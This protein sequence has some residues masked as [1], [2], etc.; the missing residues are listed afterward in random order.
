[1]E[2]A[3]VVVTGLI[4]V[5]TLVVAAVVVA[6]L[7]E[8]GKTVEVSAVVVVW[9]RLVAMGVEVVELVVT[10]GAA[11]VGVGLEVSPHASNINNTGKTSIRLLLILRELLLNNGYSAFLFP[12]LTLKTKLLT[13]Q[14]LTN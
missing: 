13:E 12:C 4:E 6:G 9:V 5:A 1:M 8:G 7:V 11:G 10:V 3:G 14:L 2:V